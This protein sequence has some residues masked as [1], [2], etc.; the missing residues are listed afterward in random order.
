MNGFFQGLDSS[1][2]VATFYALELHVIPLQV[3]CSGSRYRLFTHHGN[4]KSL[5]VRTLDD[6][7][8]QWTLIILYIIIYCKPNTWN[9]S[10]S[11]Q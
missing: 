6:G 4:L 10:Y 5:K 11:C 1:G 8:R 2:N 7:S 3:P 9:P